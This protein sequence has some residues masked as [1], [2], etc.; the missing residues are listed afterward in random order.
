MTL[1]P[2]LARCIGNTLERLGVRR[3]EASDPQGSGTKAIQ[4]VIRPAGS[5][6]EETCSGLILEDPGDTSGGRVKLEPPI[7]PSGLERALF[8]LVLRRRW[9]DFSPGGSRR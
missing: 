6:V 4:I 8:T 1:D 9:A 5:P 3:H 7:L 2:G